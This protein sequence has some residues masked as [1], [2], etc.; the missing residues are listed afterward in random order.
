MKRSEFKKEFRYNSGLGAAEMYAEKAA[1]LAEKAGVQWDPEE[2]E[3][4]A[5]VWV[6][7]GSCALWWDGRAH[8]E[9]RANLS[10][11]YQEAAARYNAVESI[12][13]GYDGL[14]HVDHVKRV[15]GS[16]RGKL[17]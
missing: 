10:P 16:E 4:P 13:T 15:L 11:V 17:Q 5:R 9:E 14:I 12:L 2:P 7:D 8:I 6:F 3:L 1:A